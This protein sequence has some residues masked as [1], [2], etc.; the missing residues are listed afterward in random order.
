M[1]GP[2]FALEAAHAALGPV[3]GV[4]EVGRGPWAGPVVAGAAILNLE[5][6]PEGLNDSKQLSAKRREALAAA[7]WADAGAVLA[8]G[9]ASVREIE[10]LGLGPACDL[11]M[12][13]AIARLRLRPGFALVDGRRLPRGLPCAGLAVVKGDARS[14]SIAAASI[15]AKVARDRAMSRLHHRRPFYGW[16]RNAGYGVSVHAEGILT[17][18]LTPHHRRNFKPIAAIVHAGGGGGEDDVL[19]R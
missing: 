5:S 13:R 7:L 18:G 3:C 4:D 16:D 14:Q 10:R 12:V 19:T 8:L 11:A 15:I 6:S 2:D 9:A 17:F 1:S